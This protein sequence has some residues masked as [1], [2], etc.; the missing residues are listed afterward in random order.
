MHSDRAPIRVK[1]RN[2]QHASVEGHRLVRD[3]IDSSGIDLEVLALFAEKVYSRRDAGA[4]GWEPK[5][6]S[7]SQ[8]LVHHYHELL[9]EGRPKANK[10][11]NDSVDRAKYSSHY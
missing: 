10:R 6:M 8:I 3:V 7:N 4:V 5:I 11:A 9:G 1:M 2:G